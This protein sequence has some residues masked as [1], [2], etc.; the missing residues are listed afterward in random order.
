MAAPLF[1]RPPTRRQN[2]R[3]VSVWSDASNIEGVGEWALHA[4]YFPLLSVC[5]RPEKDAFVLDG[6]WA[7]LRRDGVVVWSGCVENGAL[8][9]KTAVAFL[10]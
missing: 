7:S 2:K 6:P 9:R 4:P 1:P 10:P 8:A 5:T 3:P